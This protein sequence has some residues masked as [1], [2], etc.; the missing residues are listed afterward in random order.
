MT[1]IFI[2][3]GLRTPF[4]QA[5][6]FY[7]KHSALALASPLAAAMAARARPDILIWGQAIS[8][9]TVSNFARELAFGAKLDG[10]IPA[11]STVLTCSSSFM[12][13]VSAAGLIA[14]GGLHL[15]LVGGVETMSHVT[16]GLSMQLADQILAALATDAAQAAEMLSQIRPSDFDLRALGWINRRSQGEYAED[17]AS[18]FRISRADQDARALLSHQGAIDGMDS[19]FFDDLI[20][21]FDGVDYD[22]IPRRDTSLEILANL[23]TMF[24]TGGTLTAGNSSPPRPTALRRSG[25]ATS[26]AWIAWESW[27]PRS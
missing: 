26:R 20:L 22:T 15:A 18:Y 10:S 17:T 12:A 7:A 1:D 25:S 14:R 5:G 23:P 16:I 24:D 11:F 2:A 3:P 4:V 9:P 27:V 21:P 8:D 6:G 19:G 13:A